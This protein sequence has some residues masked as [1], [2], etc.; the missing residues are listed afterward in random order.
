MRCKS[1]L[2]LYLIFTVAVLHA[3]TPE[4]TSHV[5]RS[6]HVTNAMSV[7]IS[8]KYG[9]IHIVPWDV[10]SVRFDIDM[11][12]RAKDN[13]KLEKMK[14]TVEFDFTPGQYFLVAKTNF[15]VIKDLVDIAGSYLSSSSSVTINYTVRVP[16]SVSLKIENKFGDVYFDDHQGA[17]NL[18]LSYGNLKA[19]R[20]NGRSEIRITS[21]DG[22][23]NFL[24]EG[25]VTISYGNLHVQECG[26]L[27][28][29]TQSS[30]ITLDKLENLKMNSRRDKLFL[31]NVGT[32]NGESYFSKVVVGTLHNEVS[33]KSRYGDISI[34]DIKRSFSLLSLTAELTD[35]TLNFEKPMLFDF[36]LE[37]F[38]SVV[39]LYQQA[40]SHLSTKV[41]NAEEKLFSTTGS[42]GAGT[43]ESRV[44]I[45]APRKCN[46]T[47]MQK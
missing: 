19:N 22:E 26:K 45:E 11:K 7:E 12:L 21:G 14:Q 20:L 4:Y 1:Q 42:F 36:E 35:L 47:L 41:I 24:K 16:A 15:D 32:L 39:F 25:Q 9:R 8:N 13:Q 46:I 37:H 43:P 18:T 31:N 38:Q 28:L 30:V 29:Q 3:Q 23:I 33:L 40:L 44:F 5:S 2:I 6:F 27:N 17:L 34:N 10:D